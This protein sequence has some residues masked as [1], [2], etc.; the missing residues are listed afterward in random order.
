MN[1]MNNNNKKYLSQI[2]DAI[3]NG[4]YKS[5]RLVKTDPV[6]REKII[7]IPFS[8]ITEPEKGVARLKH[9]RHQIEKVL[10]PGDYIIECRTGALASS[11]VDM[12]PIK[13]PARYVPAPVQQGE[14]Q[15]STAIQESIED[16]TF[17]QET[18]QNIDFDD[19][20]AL[21]KEVEK[22]KAEK[23]LLMT[24]LEMMQRQPQLSEPAA[25]AGDKAIQALADH[26]PSILGIFQQFMNQRDEQI[27]LERDK[28]RGSN[29]RGFKKKVETRKP[30]REEILYEM[31][32][33]Q[34][35]DPDSFD[36]TLDEMEE[37]D[38]ELY[39]YICE[40]LQI[41]FEDDEDLQ[42]EGPTEE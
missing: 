12:F 13:I 33:L 25:T 42:D 28:M 31:A 29:S 8:K 5:V 41:E 15:S 19:Y 37:Q 26:A 1:M 14:N 20:V 36:A 34:E 16:K 23:A 38:P 35:R 11:L 27:K 9:I 4:I 21:I 40:N 2:S 6:T 10:E 32:A 17:E 7:L 22:L 3:E 18:M 30:T 24:Q 39:E